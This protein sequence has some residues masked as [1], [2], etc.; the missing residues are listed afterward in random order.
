[1]GRGS[2]GRLVVPYIHRGKKQEGDS[3]A[4]RARRRRSSCLSIM[5]F[6]YLRIQRTSG[7][8]HA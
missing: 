3:R 7:V 6:H 4:D 2:E 5:C 8:F 1:M